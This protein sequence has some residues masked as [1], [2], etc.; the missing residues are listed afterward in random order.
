MTSRCAL[1]RSSA[2]TTS[3]RWQPHEARRFRHEISIAGTVDDAR[4]EIY[5]AEAASR[6]VAHPSFRLD[7]GRSIDARR[8]ERRV[9]GDTDRQQVTVHGYGTRVYDPAGAGGTSRLEQ[10]AR[11]LRVRLP[12]LRGRVPVDVHGPRHMV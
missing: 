1:A 7:L 11:A 3:T 6:G 8:V 9:L 10:P 2:C 4:P 12:H 5:R